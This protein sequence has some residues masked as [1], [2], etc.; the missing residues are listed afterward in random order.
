MD[1]KYKLSPNSL[2]ISSS[3]Q[4][5]KFGK[6]LALS[7]L[8]LSRH[9]SAK[10]LLEKQEAKEEVK[11]GQY[12]NVIISVEDD[13]IIESDFKEEEQVKQQEY[14]NIQISIIDH[15]IY[16]P[17]ENFYTKNEEKLNI[18]EKK[19]KQHEIRKNNI[20]LFNKKEM[21]MDEE[22]TKSI[23]SNCSFEEL[24]KKFFVVNGAP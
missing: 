5:K 19:E 21:Q 1:Q 10:N 24:Q 18:N 12:S 7:P 23:M 4:S 16:E 13:N 14:K 6:S 11:K 22:I 8:K 15:K 20:Y 3:N 9:P 2:Q 17:G